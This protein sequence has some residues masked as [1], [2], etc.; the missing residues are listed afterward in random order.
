METAAEK[1]EGEDGSTPPFVL[2]D[3]PRGPC[4]DD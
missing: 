3:A 1:E 4:V 2:A